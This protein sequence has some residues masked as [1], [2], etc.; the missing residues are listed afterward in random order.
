ME[1]YITLFFT[2]LTNQLEDL[3]YS[4]IMKIAKEEKPNMIIAGASAYSRDTI[5]FKKFREI[6]RFY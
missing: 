6:A 3:D 1:D 5:D 2:E 4:N